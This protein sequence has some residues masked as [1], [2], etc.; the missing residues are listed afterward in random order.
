[1]AKS[2]V[3]DP[4][5]VRTALAGQTEALRAAVHALCADPVAEE[6]L[7][8]P[9]RLGEW[10]V[11]QLVAHLGYCVD[12]LPKRLKDPVPQ[13]GPLGLIEWAGLTRTAAAVVGAAAKEHAEGAF[14]GSPEEVAREF[15]QAADSLLSA[16]ESPEAAEPG[17][18][19]VG[20]FGPMLL[21]DFLVTRLVETVVHAD[22]L[23]DALG[24]AEFPHA[25][26]ALAAVSR[27][28]ADAFAEQVPGGSVE[29]RVPPYAVVQAVPGPRHTRGTP[30]NV[31]ETDPL[32][33][34]RLATG[35]TDWATAV[36][37]A[38]VSASGERSDLAEYLP[39]M[40]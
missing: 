11:R 29:L 37:S 16:L 7:D 26:Q 28:L 15:D 25:K 1:M 13:G 5:K 20:R 35:R 19:F 30:P 34:I 38:A 27:L 9:T 3:Y 8:R 31:V 21:S 17:R 22:D 6:I 36:E 39:V 10:N 4:V 14:G 40:G 33:W 32:S 12:L 2:R 18:R 23:A 24:L